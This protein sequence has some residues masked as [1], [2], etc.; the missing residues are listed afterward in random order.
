MHNSA[1]L[2]YKSNLNVIP[3]QNNT[4]TDDNIC[5]CINIGLYSVILIIK[6]LSTYI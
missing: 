3:T 5:R 4:Q 6:L 1:A 2:Q